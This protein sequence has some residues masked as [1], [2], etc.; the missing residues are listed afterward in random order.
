MSDDDTESTVS[1]LV[2]VAVRTAKML[3]EA[4][5]P[6]WAENCHVTIGQDGRVGISCRG[7]TDGAR[8]DDLVKAVSLD[9]EF[10]EAT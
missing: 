3:A 4:G 9:P 10:E 6:E 7:R 8:H 2:A 1:D 5:H